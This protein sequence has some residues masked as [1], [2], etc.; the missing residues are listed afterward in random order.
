M[1]DPASRP[2]P[3]LKTD[4]GEDEHRWPSDEVIAAARSNTAA[5]NETHASL[6]ASADALLEEVRRLL[7][8]SS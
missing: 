6:V 3:T 4:R 2:D 5:M 7:A 1:P 8:E